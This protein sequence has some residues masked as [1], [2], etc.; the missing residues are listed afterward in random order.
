MSA[1]V[2]LGA[3][4]AVVLLMSV[5]LVAGTLVSHDKAAA[6]MF[7]L[8]GGITLPLVALLYEMGT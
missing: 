2:N 3:L 7:G 5:L 4:R 6:Q 8:L 1:E